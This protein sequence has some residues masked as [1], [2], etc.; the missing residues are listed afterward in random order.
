MHKLLSLFLTPLL[1]TSCAS[2]PSLDDGL[3]SYKDKN[4]NSVFPVIGF[5]AEIE[6]ANSEISYFYQISREHVGLITEAQPATGL[7]GQDPLTAKTMMQPVQVNVECQLT[8]I[9]DMDKKIQRWHF[10]ETYEG[11]MSYREKL[12]NQQNK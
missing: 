9:T 12:A 8:I 4:I 2:L 11:C 5:P 6:A 7:E 1:L 3:A 10:K